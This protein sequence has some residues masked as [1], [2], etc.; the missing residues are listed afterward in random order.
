MEVRRELAVGRQSQLVAHHSEVEAGVDGGQVF[1]DLAAELH[2]FGDAGPGRPPEP[3]VQGV[4]G[5]WA[6]QL[7]T[8]RSPSL[9]S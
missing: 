4:L 8:V 6:V 9:R 3:S 7:N 5:V 2:E 1:A